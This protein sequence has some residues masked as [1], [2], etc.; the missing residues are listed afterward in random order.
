MAGSHPRISTSVGAP[1]IARFLVLMLLL[2]FFAGIFIKGRRASLADR[3]RPILERVSRAAMLLM[4]ALV[5]VIH[6]RGFLDISPDSRGRLDGQAPT[7]RGLISSP[8]RP[9]GTSLPLT[10]AC[11]G[12][13]IRDGG[14]GFQ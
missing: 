13:E 4:V 6:W 8:P 12:A 5:L 1:G 11:G 7:E 2:P 10:R 9:P 14:H 3:W